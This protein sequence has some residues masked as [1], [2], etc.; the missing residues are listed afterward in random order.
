M[1]CLESRA[2]MPALPEEIEEA[3]KTAH[4]V[5]PHL[6]AVKDASVQHVISFMNEAD[7]FFGPS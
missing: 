7:A 5:K 4:L 2:M 1:A 6:Q 3:R